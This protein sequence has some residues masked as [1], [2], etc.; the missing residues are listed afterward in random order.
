MEKG[1][2]KA[3]AVISLGTGP[4]EANFWAGRMSKNT[5]VLQTSYV[6]GA[7]SGFGYFT[8]PAMYRPVKSTVSVDR[9]CEPKFC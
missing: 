2:S 4:G 9:G 3:E 5:N 6:H 7:G 1:N 8:E